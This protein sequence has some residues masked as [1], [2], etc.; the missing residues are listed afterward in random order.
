VLRDFNPGYACYGSIGAPGQRGPNPLRSRFDPQAH[1]N[2][3]PYPGRRRGARA[4]RLRSPSRFKHD[5]TGTS[6]VPV[7]LSAI[8]RA[9]LGGGSGRGKQKSGNARN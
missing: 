3:S 5:E 6:E 4:V 8:L 7:S 2:S 1:A 9:R